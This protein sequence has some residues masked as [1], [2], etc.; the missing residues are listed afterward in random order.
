FSLTGM[1]P[2]GGFVGKFYI[3]KAAMDSKLYGV[4]AVGLLNSVL[5]A[6]YYLNIVVTMYMKE[7]VSEPPPVHTAPLLK[8]GII[9]STAGVLILGLFPARILEA[10]RHLLL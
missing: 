10:A 2:T 5:G 1:P 7:P 4:A 8:L 3:F 6:A 9:A